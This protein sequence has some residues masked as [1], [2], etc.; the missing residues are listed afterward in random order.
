MAIDLALFDIDM[1]VSLASIGKLAA[2]TGG[3]FYPYAAFQANLDFEQVNL[4]NLYIP[5]LIIKIQGLQYFE[6]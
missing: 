6:D 3:S 1:H 2:E 4:N 5:I